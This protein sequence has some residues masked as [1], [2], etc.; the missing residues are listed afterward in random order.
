MTTTPTQWLAPLKVNP[1]S[2]GSQNEPRITALSN[3]NFLVVFSDNSGD[4]GSGSDFDV[5][6]VI[7]DAEGN[8]VTTAFEVNTTVTSGAETE[9]DVAATNDG[10]FYLTYYTTGGNGGL[11]VERYDAGGTSIGGTELLSPRSGLGTPGDPSIAV[12]L[13]DNSFFISYERDAGALGDILG[14]RFDSSLTVAAGTPSAGHIVRADDHPALFT[15]SPGDPETVHLTNGNYATVFTYTDGSS[16][17]GYRI[18]DGTTG[19]SLV[20]LDIAATTTN[21]TEDSQGSIAALAGGGFVIAWT[22]FESTNNDDNDNIKFMLFANTG[23]PA[24][25][26]MTAIDSTSDYEFPKV[27]GLEDGGFYIVAWDKGS[28]SLEGSRYDASGTLIGINMHD[29]ANGVTGLPDHDVSLTT[30]GRILITWKNTVGDVLFTIRDPRDAEIF[31]DAGD[32]QITG[33]IDE[34]STIH[35]SSAN[36]TIHA[37]SFDDVVYAGDGADT[38]FGGDGNDLIEGGGGVDIIYGGVGFETLTGGAGSDF[39]YA[40]QS[41]VFVMTGNDE[42]DHVFGGTANDALDLTGFT[43]S[44]PMIDLVSGNY[45]AGG[46]TRTAFNVEA[47]LGNG[48]ANTI[49]GNAF[50]NVLDGGGGD[51][52][53][54]GGTTGAAADVVLGGDGDDVLYSGPGAGQIVGGIGNDTIHYLDGH[55]IDVITNGGTGH[56]IADFSA[57]TSTGHDID[58]AT[59]L[60]DGAKTIADIEHVVGTQMGDTLTGGAGAETLDGSGGSDTLNGSAGADSLDGGGGSDTLSYAGSPSKVTLSLVTG[61]GSGGDADGD[62]VANVETV[63]GSDFNDILFGDAGANGLFG[64][65]G[66]D[67]LQGGA[68]PDLLDG[69]ADLDWAGYFDA[70][71]PLTIDLATP[72][73]SSA[74]FAEDT[75]I[76]IEIIGGATN[77]S[78]T[79]QGDAAPNIFIGGSAADTVAGGGGGDLLQGGGGNDTIRGEAGTD[80]VMGNK[81]DDALYGGAQA[82]GFYFQDG[83][84][85]DVIWDFDVALDKFVFISANFD[86][87]ADLGFSEV[88]GNAVITYGAATIT[89]EGVTP[90]QIDGDSSLYQWF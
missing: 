52:V 60:I 84:G 42:I 38:V 27:V 12:N 26:V 50:F 63:V 72:A 37:Y 81:G 15:Q 31:A 58:L 34:A 24:S 54:Y 19:A 23:N 66:I 61:L 51:D 5:I 40:E 75:L 64:G 7:Y 90:G 16:H 47:I 67:V 70:P 6:G 8:V 18:S 30:D 39:L 22:E 1:S 73:N 76:S 10:G 62:T 20:Q 33:R 35:G 29:V 57:V 49:I 9:I 82:D 32:G 69:G 78:N 86:D 2:D 65:S 53:I 80:A 46:L 45:T 11:L 4:I 85:D 89:V 14:K 79:F 17:I 13:S 21:G 44:A 71:G 3:G 25:G 59:G 74:Y 28:G 68:G 41:G 77:F 56:D 87:I 83:D 55:V 48:S 36:D 88:G 43:G